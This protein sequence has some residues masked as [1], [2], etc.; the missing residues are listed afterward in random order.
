MGVCAVGGA[1][2]AWNLKL[3]YSALKDS[4]G[5]LF[6]AFADFAPTMIKAMINT[7]TPGTTNNHPFNSMW[8]AKLLSVPNGEV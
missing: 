5:F 6:A 8:W 1:R 3:S 4:T 2:R 7:N